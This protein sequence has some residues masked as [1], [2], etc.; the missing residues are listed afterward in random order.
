MAPAGDVK[1]A[2]RQAKTGADRT[3]TD[4]DTHCPHR[5]RLCR[6]LLAEKIQPRRPRWDGWRATRWPNHSVAEPLPRRAGGA[7]AVVRG[8]DGG[9]GAPLLYP[10]AKGNV[11]ALIAIQT[12]IQALPGNKR[13]RFKNSL[14]HHDVLR[15]SHHEFAATPAANSC[16]RGRRHCINSRLGTADAVADRY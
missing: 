16:P 14:Q 5:R 8:E 12:G 13:D 3:R 7:G 1:E 15:A 6:S 4:N 10:I 2:A 9:A 11:N